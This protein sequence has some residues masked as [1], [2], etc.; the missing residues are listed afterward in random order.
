MMTLL[1][2]LLLFVFDSLERFRSTHL[3]GLVCRMHLTST[4]AFMGDRVERLIEVEIDDI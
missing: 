3:W 2:L 4:A 1:H